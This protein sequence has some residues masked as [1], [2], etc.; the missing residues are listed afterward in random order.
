MKKILIPTHEISADDSGIIHIKV[1]E[2]AHIDT[3][4]LKQLNEYSLK[5]AGTKKILALVDARNFHTLTPEATAYLKTDFADKTRIATAI[6]SSKTGMRLLVDYLNNSK[7]VQSPVRMF[8][9]EKEA[10]TWLI[11]FKTKK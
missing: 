5:L 8:E 7:P 11:S 3:P 10:K 9:N 1:K 4:I 6:V 2:G